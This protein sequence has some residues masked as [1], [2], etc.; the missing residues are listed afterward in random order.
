MKDDKTLQDKWA[1]DVAKVQRALVALGLSLDD[2][3]IS[4][5]VAAKAGLTLRA[6]Q[7][8]PRA[9]DWICMSPGYSSGVS[10]GFPNSA[11]SSSMVGSVPLN[12]SGS[13][14]R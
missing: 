4:E 3:G 6:T 13:F 1:D 14:S 9:L 10:F 12:S 7:R 8:A 5:Q 2:R 11:S